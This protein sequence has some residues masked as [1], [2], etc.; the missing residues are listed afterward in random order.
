MAPMAKESVGEC[1]AQSVGDTVE[2]RPINGP[3]H[4]EVVYPIIISVAKSARP[5]PASNHAAAAMPAAMIG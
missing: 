1:P 5:T 2:E 3:Q 4:P